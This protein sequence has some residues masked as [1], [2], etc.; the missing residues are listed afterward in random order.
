MNADGTGSRQLSDAGVMGHFMRWS[1]GGDAIIFR[2]PGGG[3]PRTVKVG[4][5]GSDA[6]PL[7]EVVGGAHMSLSPDHSRIMDVV[8]HKTL[9]VSPLE[10]GKPEKVFE[11]DDPDV[12]IDYPVWSPDGNRVAF[13]NVD[14][15]NRDI[16]VQSVSGT[17]QRE[18]LVSGEKYDALVMVDD[19][20]KQTRLK[21]EGR[22]ADIAPTMLDILGIEK[23]R[24]MTGE[25]LL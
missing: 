20:R 2:V 6:G 8:G 25:S 3:S 9:W 16:F 5:D 10:M 22:L 7:P 13:V 19:S 11:F 18:L 4:L 12:R 23:P 17:T 14:S 24:E 1:Q 15:G 21:E